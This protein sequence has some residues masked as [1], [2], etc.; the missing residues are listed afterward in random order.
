MPLKKIIS[1][2]FYLSLFLQSAKA[3][4]WK[5][6]S[7]GNW[8][9][10]STWQGGVAPP[11]SSSDTFLIK[12]NININS[13]LTLATNAFLQI[14]STGGICGHYT[15]TVQSGAKIIKYGTINLD[16][17]NVPGG[18]VNCYNPGAVIITQYGVISNGGQLSTFGCAF[19]VGPWFTCIFPGDDDIETFEKLGFNLYP[20]PNKG[21]F[22][23]ETKACI[24]VQLYNVTG[25]MFLNKSINNKALIDANNLSEGVYF[26]QIKTNQ[27]T[28]TQ[29]III[30]P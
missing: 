27:N 11:S 12:H 1:I 14:D 5:T 18:L 21:I 9:A 26:M 13:N 22:T 3:L 17:I 24:T 19:T 30:Q 6:V 16:V 15:V 2:I 29:K 8:V 20:N 4:T 25:N 28:Y 23:I 7:N 10:G